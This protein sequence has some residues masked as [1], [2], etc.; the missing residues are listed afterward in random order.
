MVAFSAYILISNSRATTP[1]PPAMSPAI[2]SFS[3]CNY[4][5]IVLG[6]GGKKIKS[7]TQKKLL[8]FTLILKVY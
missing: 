7:K 1:F 2:F 4:T 5:E 8:G 6:D 3:T